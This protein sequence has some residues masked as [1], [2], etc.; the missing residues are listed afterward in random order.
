MKK[1]EISNYSQKFFMPNA[2]ISLEF[3]SQFDRNLPYEDSAH[4][5]LKSGQATNA[6]FQAMDAYK[7][8]GADT[9][10]G[11]ATTT[12]WDYWNNSPYL[13]LDRN[14][15]R[16]MIA[17]QWKPIEGG[18]KIAEIARCKAELNELQAYL[19]QVN[20]ELEM[21]VREV[22]NR[23]ISKY[24]MIEKSYKA[25]FAEAENYQMVKARYLQGKSPINQLADAQH[26][27]LGAKLEA[28]NSQ[29]NFFKELFW[30]QRGLVSINWTKA[31]EE[32]KNWI[33]NV[34]TYL[35]AEE[36]FSL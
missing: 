9:A 26:L 31:T 3:G 11:A 20:T 21:N 13:G 14:Y 24:F 1:A 30:V 4:N 15:T 34:P 18:H 12:Y 10:I 5:Q 29:Y 8:A 25:M 36:D 16:F 27:Y 2:K 35:P 19:E 6:G 23:A 7:G 22:V 17:A 32:A 33:N 28:M